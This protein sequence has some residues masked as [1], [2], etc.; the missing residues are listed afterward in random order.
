M[1]NLWRASPRNGEISDLINYRRKHFDWWMLTI[2]KN[3]RREDSLHYLIGLVN[4]QWSFA[5]RM[6]PAWRWLPIKRIWDDKSG[7][8]CLLELRNV[9]RKGA[10]FLTGKV[11]VIFLCALSC[12]PGTF[13]SLVPCNRSQKIWD[14]VAVANKE[15]LWNTQSLPLLFFFFFSPL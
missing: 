8:C 1:A 5:S 10:L 12:H 2:S 4:F 9:D 3:Y 13:M 15:I 7:F 14:H 11:T 6:P